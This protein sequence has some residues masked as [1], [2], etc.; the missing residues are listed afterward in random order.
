VGVSL[1]GI[2]PPPRGGGGGAVAV[3]CVWYLRCSGACM[4][5]VL[6]WPQWT[7]WGGLVAQPCPG[8]VK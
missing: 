1:L 8:L 5:T 7:W 3:L 6:D 4:V 2:G